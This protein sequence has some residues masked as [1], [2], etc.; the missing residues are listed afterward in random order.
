MFPFHSRITEITIV[1]ASYSLCIADTFSFKTGCNDWRTW[2]WRWEDWSSHTTN[3]E[4]IHGPNSRPRSSDTQECRCI[5]DVQPFLASTVKA[6][7]QWAWLSIYCNNKPVA[8]IWLMF[9]R[10]TMHHCCFKQNTM[11]YKSNNV[12]EI[13]NLIVQP[14][15]K[16][17]H[18]GWSQSI[19]CVLFVSFIFFIL[20]ICVANTRN[21]PVLL[22]T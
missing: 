22:P 5:I 10:C 15:C 19:W 13:I 17:L 8:T 20:I 12:L 16:R 6:N 3:P 18:L 4:C 2:N 14:V 9:K 7:S 21:L 1:G 11:Y